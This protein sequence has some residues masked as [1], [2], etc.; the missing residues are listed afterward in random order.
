MCQEGLV[1]DS[2][3]F[4]IAIKACAN[5]VIERHCLALHS[6]IVKSGLEDNMVLSNVLIHAYAHCSTIKSAE[7]VFKQMKVRDE[8]SWNSMIKAYAALGQGREA[9]GAFRCI[10]VPLDSATFVGVLMAC[11]H[12]EI[13]NEGR[14]IFKA[15][16]NM[17][18][19]LPQLDYF[20]CMV[21][22]LGHAGD[23]LAAENLVDQMPM[24]P[25]YDVWSAFLGACRK[26]KDV[27]TGRKA[28]QKLMELEPHNSF[29]YVMMSNIYCAMGSLS[30]AAL[31]RKEMKD[32]NVK[33]DPGQSWIKIGNCVHEFFV[34]VGDTHREKQYMWR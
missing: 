2:Y 29:G 15:M 14:I 12:G 25:D 1:P 9:L 27:K 6:L 17:Y 3:T 21:D 30:D 20:A 16:T 11:S 24:E 7:H 32:N 4:S 8:V 13:V 28:A 26:H 23:L 18:G 5:F 31:A 19:I 10:Y 22:I 33:K 34:V